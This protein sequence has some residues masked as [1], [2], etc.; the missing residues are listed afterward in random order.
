MID[1]MDAR[2]LSASR[3]IVVKY[4]SNSAAGTDSARCAYATA[5]G[6]GARAK[7][8]VPFTTALTG[9]PVIASN[10]PVAK[11][12]VVSTPSES[13]TMSVKVFPNPSTSNFNLQV[14]TG[15]SEEITA[16]VLDMQGRFLKSVV[17][18]PN[19][20]INLGSE[21]KA[22]SYFI[23]VRQGKEVKTTRV[24]KF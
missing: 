20:T 1:S 13:M 7:A 19:K 2:G 12:A 24:I 15:G 6:S 5:C 16:R 21:L 23:E 10:L 14:N 9:C 17:I 8:K 22:G 18:S 3:V 11:A 4:L